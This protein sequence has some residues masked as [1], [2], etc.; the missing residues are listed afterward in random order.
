MEDFMDNQSKTALDLFDGGHNCAQS[1]LAVF[2]E[3]YGLDK[4]TALTLTAGLGSGFR[5]GE[6]C[7]AAVAAALV[8]GL[9]YGGEKS[10]CAKKTA[11]LIKCFKNENGSV[12]CREILSRNKGR[13]C[14]ALVQS[15]VETLKEMGY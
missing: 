12:I 10:E 5:S 9:K 15:A 8:V 1:V 7:G 13:K 2:C 11:E 14:G 4:N 6:M 3:E